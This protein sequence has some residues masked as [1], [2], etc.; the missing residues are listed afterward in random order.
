M[1]TETEEG[2][3]DHHHHLPATEDWPQGFGE[4]SWWPFVT[5]AGAAGIYVGV[6]L[7]IIEGVVGPMAGPAVI[8]GSVGL[9]LTGIY[10]WLYHA[11]VKKFWS[12]DTNENG[13]ASLRYGM[14]AFPRLRTGD[15]WRDIQL[16]LLLPC[17]PGVDAAI[18]DAGSD[19]F[20]DPCQH[21]DPDRLL[22]HAPLGPRR[23]SER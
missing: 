13:I 6:A 10:G 21:G 12:R 20:A 23:P 19:Q 8:A 2:H 4:A 14:I 7:F 17:R 22:V 11:F 3:D 1:S 9:F 18:D 16:L 15:V 5:A